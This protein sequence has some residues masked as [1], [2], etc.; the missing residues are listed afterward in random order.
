M[1]GENNGNAAV[2]HYDTVGADSASV[3]VSTVGF[4]SGNTADQIIG[5]S[6]RGPGIGGTLKPDIAAPGVNILAQGYT[7]GVTG[8]D[9]HLGYGQASGTSMAG[10]HVAGAAVLLKQLHPSWSNAIYQI[11][12]DVYSQIHGHLQY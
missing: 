9:R 8:E 10:P 2:E 11:C 3:E 1:I 4:Q 5:F 6:S 7:N 12:F